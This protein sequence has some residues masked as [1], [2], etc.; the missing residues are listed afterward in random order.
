MILCNQSIEI[1]LERLKVMVCLLL[2]DNG[3]LND[4][5]QQNSGFRADN[6]RFLPF[7][8]CGSTKFT[9]W[10]LHMHYISENTHL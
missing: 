5:P 7:A 1:D 9:F 3:R 8:E 6:A 2:L 10:A 4:Q